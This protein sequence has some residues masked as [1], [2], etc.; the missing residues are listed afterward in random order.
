M[1]STRADDVG[2]WKV[3][4]QQ[5][6]DDVKRLQGELK[7]ITHESEQEI[8]QLKAAHKAEEKKTRDLQI[9]LQREIDETLDRLREEKDMVTAEMN[10]MMELYQT[11][12]EE[13][14]KHS[15]DM[16]ILRAEKCSLEECVREL[17][18]EKM[19]KEKLHELTASEKRDLKEK[20]EERES[21]IAAMEIRLKDVHS[22]WIETK[23]QL[24]GAIADTSR[25][26]DETLSKTQQVKQFKKQSD[27]YRDQLQQERVLS[28]SLIK[29]ERG[30]MQHQIQEGRVSMEHQIQE[31]RV[32]MQHQIQEERVSMQHQIQE[33]R[34]KMQRQV[35]MFQEDIRSKEE[36]HTAEVSEK[37]PFY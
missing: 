16:E 30:K 3:L 13:N 5:Y 12:R 27:T 7:L 29:E 23:E 35:A 24:D 33:E 26:T 37:Q 6:A 11:E 20:L 15:E 32:S 17:E 36:E 34:V 8:F 22:K 19:K 4:E 10:R 1:A 9:T 21:T 18:N 14:K 25:L 28:Q 2:K 31:E